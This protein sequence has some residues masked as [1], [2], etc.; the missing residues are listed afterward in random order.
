V[1]IP[2]DRLLAESPNNG[3]AKLAQAT[4]AHLESADTATASFWP[5]YSV[6]LFVLN[7]GLNLRRVQRTAHMRRLLA[8]LPGLSTAAHSKLTSVKDAGKLFSLE[9]LLGEQFCVHPEHMTPGAV[10]L[11]EHSAGGT[12]TPIVVRISNQRA[13]N[14]QVRL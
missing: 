7:L 5:F 1:T 10:V 8:M 14:V 12:M 13:V 2:G 6:E 9:L 4:M 11:F 3:L